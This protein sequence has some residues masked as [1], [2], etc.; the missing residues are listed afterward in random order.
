MIRLRTMVAAATILLAAALAAPAAA[1]DETI[2]FDY[3]IFRQ[4]DTLAV[5]VDLTP[6]MNQRRMEDLLAGLA[7]RITIDCRLEKPRRP[8]PARTLAAARAVVTLTRRLTEDDYAIQVVG[9][10]AA[11]Y[12][13]ASQLE[14]S[15]CLA[16]SMIFP[17]I[18]GAIAPPGDKVRLGLDLSCS[19]LNPNALIDSAS[20]AV[21]GGG[22]FDRLFDLFA[23]TVGW[24]ADTYRI[25]SP[26]FDPAAL[27]EPR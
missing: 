20:V 1:A 8:L 27:A 15:D 4:G 22:L 5:W 12:K 11:K 19:S 14:L 18:A 21:P 23:E 9:A 26:L 17:I 16:D 13:F 25:V 7:V 10:G 2:S 24:G 6:V 3:D